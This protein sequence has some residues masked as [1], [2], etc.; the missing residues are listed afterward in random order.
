[1]T[2]LLASPQLASA[3][4]FDAP[5]KTI[6]GLNATLLDTMKQAQAL[7]VQGRFNALAP[8]L[9]K[10]YDIQSMSR[11]AVGQS[12][13][14]FQPEQKAAVTDAF[15]RMMIA[16]YAKRFDGFSG[17]TF[18]IAEITDRP[19]SDKMVKTRIVQSN[20]KPVAINYLL[21]KTG[22]QWRIVDVYLD[23]TIS[24]LASRRAE[25]SSILKAGGPDALIASLKKQGDRLLSGS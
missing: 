2:A 22:Q 17:E 20:G 16:T 1:M 3:Q 5:E 15:A 24:E 4:A 12:W 25:F 11:V 7:G 10:T 19:P 9:S 18:E 14:T 8:V 13:D 21:R 23:G 6:S